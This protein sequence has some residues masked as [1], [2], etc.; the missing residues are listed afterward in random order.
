MLKN[1]RMTEYCNLIVYTIVGPG[2]DSDLLQN[3]GPG[4]GSYLL[5]SSSISYQEPSTDLA[6]K[7]WLLIL[8]S[9][10]SKTLL[11]MLRKIQVNAHQ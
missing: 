9:S 3:V 7:W 5:Q 8:V 4:L 2:L 10:I 1:L 6:N 11:K